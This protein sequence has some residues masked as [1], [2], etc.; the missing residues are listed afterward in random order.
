MAV[1]IDEVIEK[2]GIF[3]NKTVLKPNY[4]PENVNDVLHSR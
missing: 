1:D 2:G 3:K 4:T